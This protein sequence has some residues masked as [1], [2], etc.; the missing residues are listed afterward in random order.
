[1]LSELLQ[2][3]SI[4]DIILSDQQLAY[5]FVKSE[6]DTAISDEKSV[7]SQERD[8]NFAITADG[9]IKLNKIDVKP[10]KGKQAGD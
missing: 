9:I 6:N 5:C 1:M 4:Y 7:W 3:K 10:L 8:Y 2:S